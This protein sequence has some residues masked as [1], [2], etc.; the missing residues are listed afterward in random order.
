M[1]FVCIVFTFEWS[2]WCYALHGLLAAFY[3]M[4]YKVNDLLAYLVTHPPNLNDI[5]L[6]S[7]SVPSDPWEIGPELTMDYPL[8][9]PLICRCARE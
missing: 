9:N 7:Y 6:N 8:D 1:Y 4:A 3:F 5:L 2:K